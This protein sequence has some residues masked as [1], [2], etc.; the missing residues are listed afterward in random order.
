MFRIINVGERTCKLTWSRN[1]S[2]INGTGMV[3]YLPVEATLY[4]SPY[5]VITP[6]GYTNCKYPPLIALLPWKCQY[7]IHLVAFCFFLP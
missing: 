7:T 4:A 3:Y 5:L 1:W 2:S 6:Q